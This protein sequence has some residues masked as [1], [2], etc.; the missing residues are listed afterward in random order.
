DGNSAPQ[1]SAVEA[2]SDGPSN[3]YLDFNDSYDCSPLPE[4]AEHCA[5]GADCNVFSGNLAIDAGGTATDGAVVYM[6]EH[7]I[8]F[9][10]RIRLRANRGGYALLL[11]N[12]WSTVR[13][14]LFADDEYT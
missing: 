1:G 10:N 11:E 3:S 7:S 8:L 13:N 12:H 4:Y 5:V 2:T 6:G 14:C 9:A